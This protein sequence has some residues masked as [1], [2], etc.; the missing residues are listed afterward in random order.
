VVGAA[1][2]PL[3]GPFPGLEELVT[4]VAAHIVEGTQGSILI[5]G[6]KG[7]L[8]AER[9][10]ALISRGSQILRAADA[11][12]AP[13]EE[14]LELS[15]EH[16]IVRVGFGGERATLAEGSQGRSERFRGNRYHGGHSLRIAVSY[17]IY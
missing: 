16:P 17:H 6:E 13:V 5:S 4:A 9:H 1:D 7:R 8:E 10:R 14:V 15:P 3:V 12:P 2:E 11:N